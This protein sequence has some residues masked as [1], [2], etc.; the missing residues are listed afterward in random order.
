MW[1]KKGKHALAD[2][3]G[4]SCA[5][6][7]E[8]LSAVG[9]LCGSSPIQMAT[10]KIGLFYIVLLCFLPHP[11][12]WSQT[13]EANTAAHILAEYGLRRLSGGR[14]ISE[15]SFEVAGVMGRFWENQDR[16]QNRFDLRCR[17]GSSE[18]FRSARVD[19]DRK[20]SKLVR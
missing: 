13:P 16:V 9:A 7:C 1:S 15:G 14:E 6:W 8:A 19:S 20:S 2:A 3:P 17:G 18:L 11:E 4:S 10:F 12:P 5:Q